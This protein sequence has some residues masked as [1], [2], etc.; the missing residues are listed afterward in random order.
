M[1]QGLCI[2]IKKTL[3]IYFR[4]SKTWFKAFQ[5]FYPQYAPHMPQRPHRSFGRSPVPPARFHIFPNTH[6]PLPVMIAAFARFFYKPANFLPD[7]WAQLLCGRLQIISQILRNAV[8]IPAPER[9]RQL[10][11]VF[12][13]C[14][15]PAYH[16]L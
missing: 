14:V 2:L 9:I 13:C 7:L 6:E 16:I 8:Y 4:G 3:T 12:L 10:A 15:Y 1:P 5:S 11:A